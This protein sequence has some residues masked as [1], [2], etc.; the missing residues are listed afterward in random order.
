M[1]ENMEAENVSIKALVFENKT[2]NTITICKEGKGG[3][4][5][6]DSTLESAKR[7]FTEAMN[8]FFAIENI[9]TFYEAVKNADINIYGGKPFEPNSKQ[10]VEF[11]NVDF[12]A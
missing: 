4:I 12:A 3:P 5:I 11:V 6:T 9:V 7:R 1:Y 8:L 2:E 10:K